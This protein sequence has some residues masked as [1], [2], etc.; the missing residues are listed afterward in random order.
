MST[1]LRGQHVSGHEVAA[2][3]VDEHGEV[4][5]QQRGFDQLPT[6]RSCPG[7]ESGQDVAEGVDAGAY[8]DEGDPDGDRWAARRA[9]DAHQP[10]QSRHHDV[11]ACPIA[12]WPRCAIASYRAVDQARVQGVQILVGKAEPG[13]HPGPEALNE[14]VGPGRQLPRQRRTAAVPE[15]ECETP[16]V[17]VQSHEVRRLA[18]DEGRA[19]RTAVI[20]D[21][22]P[23]HLDDV[24][25][26]ISEKHRAIGTGNNSAE[27]DDTDRAQDTIGTGPALP[28]ARCQRGWVVRRWRISARGLSSRRHVRRG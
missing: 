21:T 12:V 19:E 22:G 10:A 7:D 17:A 14:H 28:P 5:G 3:R 6:S 26:E 1:P 16:L 11:V 9:G 27:V 25:P 13:H 4:G 2:G 20:A 23:L 18:P 24:C 8:I 15:I